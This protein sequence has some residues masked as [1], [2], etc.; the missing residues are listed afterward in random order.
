MGAVSCNIACLRPDSAHL[1]LPFSFWPALLAGGWFA[2]RNR[3]NRLHWLAL[4]PVPASWWAWRDLWPP[5]LLRSRMGCLYWGYCCSWR[6]TCTGCH[7]MRPSQ[8]S[9]GLCGT[10]LWGTFRNQIGAIFSKCQFTVI[11]LLLWAK[12][13]PLVCS[14]HAGQQLEC[15]QFHAGFTGWIL[16]PLSI[17]HYSL[18]NMIGQSC[19]RQTVSVVWCED[20]IYYC[21]SGK[22]N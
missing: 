12:M 9:A 22:S 10:W 17:I 8:T 7:P 6:T 18:G 3:W 16:S 2:G 15:S 20:L 5:L 14:Q 19:M 4:P 21:Q 11:V 1:P 13:V